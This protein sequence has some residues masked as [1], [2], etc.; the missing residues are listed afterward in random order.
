M[1]WYVPYLSVCLLLTGCIATVDDTSTL[2]ARVTNL[3][4]R[5]NGM[6]QGVAKSASGADQ[7]RGSVEQRMNT[8]LRDQ[9]Y[10]R[11]D[12]D[13]LS[14]AVARLEE[15][16]SGARI[17]LSRL[18]DRFDQIET[19]ALAREKTMA[20]RMDSVAGVSGQ[21]R[22]ELDQ[23]RQQALE[24]IQK[25]S[26]AD[27]RSKSALADLTERMKLLD[28]EVES[29]YNDLM[30]ELSGGQTRPATADGYHVVKAGETL[31]GIAA[32][33]GVRLDA[34]LKA[35]PQIT[36]PELIQVGDRIKIPS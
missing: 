9:Q 22:G 26:Q 25:A 27:E 12:L 8:L 11:K 18:K 5:I 14:A 24:A 1:R 30:K 32:R 2:R 10:L 35:N 31:G 21:F 19:G 29:L 17:E 6:E 20:N 3:E 13:E 4:N 33:Y 36:R 16:T 23:I 28:R 7:L 34:I 15:N